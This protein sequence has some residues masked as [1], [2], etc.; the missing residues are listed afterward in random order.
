MGVMLTNSNVPLTDE[1]GGNNFFPKKI[2]II[3]KP[4]FVIG[5]FVYGG[6]KLYL[7]LI[8]IKPILY[9]RKKLPTKKH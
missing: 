5:T 9:L 6:K 2:I 8:K 4:L 1:C 7:I 3:N